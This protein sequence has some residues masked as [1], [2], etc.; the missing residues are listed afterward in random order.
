MTFSLAT[1]TPLVWG[2]LA[3]GFVLGLVYVI[4]RWLGC[5]R[6]SQFVNVTEQNREYTDELPPVSVIVD[7]CNETDQLVRF[8]PLVL[9]Q[10]YPEYDVVVIADGAAEATSDMLSEMKAQH[11]N[12]HITFTPHG[13]R[14]LSRKKLALMIGIKAASHEIILTT[15]ANCR[16][17]SDQWLRLMMRNFVEGTDVV[18]GYSH[19]RYHRDKR[20]A[21]HWRILDT[22]TTGAQWLRSAIAHRPYRGVTDNLAYRKHLFFDVNGF[23]DTMNLTW[24]EDDVFLCQ[25]A[26]GDNTRVELSP[27]S[28]LSVYYENIL[29][30][31]RLLR[32]RR[33]FTS[34]MVPRRAFI[35]HALMSWVLWIAHALLVAAAVI[36]WPCAIPLIAAAVTLIALWITVIIVTRRECKLLQAPPIRLTVPLLTLARPIINFKYRIRELRHKKSNYTTYI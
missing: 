6:L 33:D 29:R 26:R 16:P 2:L 17:T 5:R 24:G 25:I 28:Q 10:D 36:A 9:N 35:E 18:L 22:V 12:L 8:L 31:H 23:A 27:E 34:R 11:P 7:A 20:W 4:W 1:I 13:T 30:A 19:Y 15:N 32:T 14:S 3:G 21:R